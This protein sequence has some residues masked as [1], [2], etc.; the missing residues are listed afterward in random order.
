MADIR[1]TA[2]S[3]RNQRI[4]N[5]ENDQTDGEVENVAQC[6]AA[7]ELLDYKKPDSDNNLQ[8]KKLATSK[9]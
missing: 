7:P 2:V 6:G 8:P 1:F 4:M 5:D 9:I 3:L